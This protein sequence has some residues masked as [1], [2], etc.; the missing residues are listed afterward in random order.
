MKHL[1]ERNE[2]LNEEF[3]FGKNLL[4]KSQEFMDEVGDLFTEIFLPNEELERMVDC[5]SFREGVVNNKS[6]LKQVREIVDAN[7]PR[8]MA[9]Y[10]RVMGVNEQCLSGIIISIAVM[11]GFYYAMKRGW[12][13]KLLKKIDPKLGR[14][15]GEYDGGYEKEW[16]KPKKKAL[17]KEK[18]YKSKEQR[19]DEILDKI[20]RR[21][22]RSLSD[23]EKA[24]LKRK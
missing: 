12:I 1:L 3:S 21:G 19:T 2:F 24:Y 23:E 13:D 6:F 4:R 18:V 17:P 20:N 9:A 10:N 8:V 5:Q 15:P 11:V 14:R 7:E 22:Y 16:E